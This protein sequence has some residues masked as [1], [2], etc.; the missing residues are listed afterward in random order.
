[1]QFLHIQTVVLLFWWSNFPLTVLSVLL[2]SR[3]LPVMISTVSLHRSTPLHCHRQ[4]SRCIS[5][6]QQIPSLNQ[7]SDFTYQPVFLQTPPTMY[8]SRHPTTFN[9]HPRHASSKPSPD[10]P[11]GHMVLFHVLL[12]V[13][14]CVWTCG[15]SLGGQQSL[16]SIVHYLILDDS[17]SL[18][19]EIMG[20]FP[21]ACSCTECFYV[22]DEDLISCLSSTYLT[23][24]AISPAPFWLFLQEARAVPSTWALFIVAQCLAIADTRLFIEWN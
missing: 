6:Q 11:K 8:P 19:L 23:D 4:H 14:E 18:I 10:F 1:M 16:A 21:G 24:W 2:I 22:V 17:V 15:C 9:G 3:F 13:Y 5:K 7:T 20:G 12:L